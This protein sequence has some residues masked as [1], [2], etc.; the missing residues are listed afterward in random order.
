MWQVNQAHWQ[1]FSRCKQTGGEGIQSFRMDEKESSAPVR[2]GETMGTL[3]MLEAGLPQG[4]RLATAHSLAS[5]DTGL[6]S[7]SAKKAG[8]EGPGKRIHFASNLQL[9]VRVGLGLTLLMAK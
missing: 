2:S 5:I 7:S 6:Y 8:G 3:D 1:V 4:A 9:R